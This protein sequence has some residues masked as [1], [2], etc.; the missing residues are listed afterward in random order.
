M[1]T[2]V[3]IYCKDSDKIFDREH[4]MPEAFGTFEPDS[5]VLDCVCKECNG[6]FGRNL[7]FALSRDSSEAVLRLRYGVKPA[8][9]AKDLQYQKLEIKVG[10]PGP[11]FGAMAILE[12]DASGIGVEPVPVPQVAF[13]WK[14]QQ[15]LT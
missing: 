7:E 10:Q 15:E 9:E 12:A 6:Y 14:G 1:T 11:W 3:C 4:V 13:R 8:S 2:Q 5:S